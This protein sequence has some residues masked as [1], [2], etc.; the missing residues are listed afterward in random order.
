MNIKTTVLGID[1]RQAEYWLFKDDLTRI[2]I[3]RKGSLERPMG[4]LEQV[5][6]ETSK[7]FLPGAEPPV[8]GDQDEVMKDEDQPNKIQE[9]QHKKS[10]DTWFF[11]EEEEDFE[12]LLESLNAK[13][14][15]EKKLI[16]SLKKIRGSLKLKKAKKVASPALL[17]A[18]GQAKS[19]PDDA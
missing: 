13:G 15:H 6:E 9:S 7:D 14:I 16:E 3:K 10:T 1:Q 19:A 17:D 11:I 5:G 2:Y 4:S 8:N 12:T 18:S